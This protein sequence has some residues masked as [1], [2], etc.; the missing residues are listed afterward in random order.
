ME[1]VDLKEILHHSLPLFHDA[2]RDKGIAFDFQLRADRTLVIGAASRLHQIVNNLLSNAIKFTA[3]KGEIA[4]AL[5]EHGQDL[6]LTVRDNGSGIDAEKL[7]RIFQPFEQ[8]DRQLAKSQGGL[9][10]GLTIARAIAESHG[11]QLTAESPGRGR[12]ATFTLQL[13]LAKEQ[14]RPQTSSP[15]R[16]LAGAE[17][18]P[19]I[20]LVDDHADTLRTLASLLRKAGYEVA[21]AESV[22]QAEPL[23]SQCDVLIT[24]IGLPDGDGY[25]LMT[26]FKAGGGKGG[27]AISGFGQ[28]E[29]I[30][31]SHRSGFSKHLIKPIDIEVL[32]AALQALQPVHS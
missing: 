9:G 32:K 5:E 30:L 2:I 28:E 13:P 21:T 1:L 31:R 17:F 7:E 10:L 19:K 8:A 3:E 25:D 4:I 27:I 29:D 22:G 16:N 11:G 18:K 26:R 14:S 12:G 23:F 15:A 6:H 24:D 20:L